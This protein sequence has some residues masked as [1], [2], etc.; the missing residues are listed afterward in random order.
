MCKTHLELERKQL[1]IVQRI[2]FKKENFADFA[3]WKT[4]IYLK[5][6]SEKV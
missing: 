5:T 3:N 4:K 6:R 1:E 2:F